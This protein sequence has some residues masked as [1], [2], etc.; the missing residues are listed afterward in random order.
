M[1][2]SPSRYVPDSD[3]LLERSTTEARL[4]ANAS[5]EEAAAAHRK[6]AS[7]YLA[8][9]FSDEKLPLCDHK[10]SSVPNVPAGSKA[11]APSSLRFADLRS[12]PEDAEL[13]RIL[14]SLQ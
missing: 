13:T 12:V 3:Y 10:L 2:F 14:H 9:L 7:C 1:S 4:A 8:K 5:T 6:I 11:V